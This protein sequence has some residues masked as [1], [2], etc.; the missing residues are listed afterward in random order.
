MCKQNI[1]L[2]FL[3]KTWELYKWITKNPA[4]LLI[5]LVDTLFLVKVIVIHI[6]KCKI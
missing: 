6:F 1:N 4:L 5:E 2:Y 3:Y